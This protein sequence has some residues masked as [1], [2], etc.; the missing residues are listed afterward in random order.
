MTANP[1]ARENP[2][3]GILASMETPTLEGRVVRLEP[4]EERHRSELL[5]I[6]GDPAIW[7][8]SPIDRAGGPFARWLNVWLDQAL[9]TRSQGDVPFAVRELNSGAIVG[10]T[11][12]LNVAPADK[13]VE[14]G[15]T[16]YE[17][18]ARG[19]AVN[20]ACKLLL[21]AHAFDRL[22]CVRVELRCDARNSASRAAI[23]KLGAR[24]E[25]ILRRHRVLAD[26]FIRDTVVFAILDHEWPAVR[27]SLE[28]RLAR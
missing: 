4:L 3:L 6:D 26:G 8:F 9:A 7:Q 13:R 2:E 20:A 1:P 15:A 17:A 5:A 21:L 11:R 25:A 24:Q 10:A 18:R 27:A 28:A 16:W 12:Y 22:G 23:A 14:I 19:T